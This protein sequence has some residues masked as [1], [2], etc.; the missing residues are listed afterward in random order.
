MF[1]RLINIPKTRSC[2][3]FGARGTGK[4]TLLREAFPAR[5][6]LNY[7]LLEA[8]TEDRLSSDPGTLEREVLAL[9]PETTHVVVDEV[10]KIPRLLNAVH[11]LLET[12]QVPQAFI[13]TGSSAR[14]LKSGGTNLLAGRASLRHL[15]PLSRRELGDAFDLERA[16]AFGG[17]PEIW[18]LPT[19]A[20]RGDYLRA[21]AHGYLREEIRAEQV[22]RRLD[23]FRRF[24]EVAAQGSGKIVNYAKIA[25]DTGS[26]PKSVQAW[27]E[28]LEDTLMGFHVD[29]YHGS[30]R[31]QLHGAPK[32]FLFDLGVTRAMARLLNVAPQPGTSYYGEL[33]EH[34]VVTEIFT[35]SFY[36]DLDWRFSY[37]LTKAGAEIDLVV[38][39]PGRPL[40]LVEIKS[41]REIREEHAAGMRRFLDDFPD[42]E[43]FLLSQDPRPQRLGRIQALPW[44][45]GILAI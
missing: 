11:N 42:A 40:A 44:E 17:L 23:P 14:K 20:D 31:K 38:T 32:F 21:Y 25:R 12:H 29:G 16:M 18:N 35:R 37:L 6:T 36:E 27:Y 26:D 33:F 45:Q 24:L 30:V 2:F 19:D 28:V 3:L 43:F 5:S 15:F 10:Q 39:R 4:S 41:T 9:G 1:H 13:L 34:L 7:N 8:E 22:V